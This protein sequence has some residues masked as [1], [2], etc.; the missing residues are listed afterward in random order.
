M[1]LTLFGAFEGSVLS[2]WIV[3]VRDVFFGWES[4]DG[5]GA[6]VPAH[7]SCSKR[8]RACQPRLNLVLD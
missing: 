5:A 6:T 1:T 4:G 3:D 7:S 2:E 8:A